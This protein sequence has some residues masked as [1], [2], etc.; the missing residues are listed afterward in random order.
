VNVLFFLL[1][2]WVSFFSCERPGGPDLGE[3]LVFS[4]AIDD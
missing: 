2:I 3:G 4:I 1:A